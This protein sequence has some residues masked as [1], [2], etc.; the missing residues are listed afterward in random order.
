M[1]NTGCI[2][3]TIN[4]HNI[5]K[6][7]LLI[8]NQSCITLIES[9]LTDSPTCDTLP[10]ITSVAGCCAELL[11]FLLLEE[12][13]VSLY[14]SCNQTVPDAC[15]TSSGSKTLSIQL[16]L[17]IP[18][19]WTELHR[20]NLSNAIQNDTGFIL[21]I[22][23]PSIILEDIAPD[24]TAS[25]NANTVITLLIQGNSDAQMERFQETYQK[26]INSQ[27]IFLYFTQMLYSNY[28]FHQ[29][30]KVIDVSIQQQVPPQ[31]DSSSLAT[32]VA[33]NVVITAATVMVATLL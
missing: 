21:G 33:T 5:A 24:N 27:T 28:Y 23:P 12:T 14:E 15:P 25:E 29:E 31:P 19:S 3:S 2:S 20:S 13:G 26:M 9:I 17:S 6:L 22:Y 16:T 18:Y 11:E 10:N 32:T 7:I 30:V 8:G 1:I 4:H